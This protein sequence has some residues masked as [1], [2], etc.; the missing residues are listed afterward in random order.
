MGKPLNQ[1]LGEIK[2]VGKRVNELINLAPSQLEEQLIKQNE[3]G[4]L[5]IRREPVGVV[6]LISPWNYPLITAVNTLIAAVLA[7]NTVLLK[8]SPLTPLCGKAFQ[9][10]FEYAG[11]KNVVNDL[12]LDVK[13][14]EN[15][16]GCEEIGYVSFTGSVTGGRLR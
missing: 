8:H 1:A 3:N 12:M 13:S 14:L 15:L 11:V 16:Y 5:K 7:G 2:T 10:A 9:D 4:L 6:L